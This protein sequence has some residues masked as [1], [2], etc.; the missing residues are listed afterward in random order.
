M[1][2]VAGVTEHAPIGLLDDLETVAAETGATVQGFDA[3]FVVSEHHLERAVELADRAI[4]RGEPIADDRSV[5]I[6]LYAAGRRQIERAFEMGLK[7]EAHPIVVVVDGGDE[8]AAVHAVESLL[9]ETTDPQAILGDHERL[10]AYFDITTA[11]R[12]TGAALEDLVLERV[13]LLTID[14]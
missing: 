5:E 2:L 12:D 7:E 1:E 9:D 10:C 13:A 6:L 8:T 14:K 11:E 3:R 4:E